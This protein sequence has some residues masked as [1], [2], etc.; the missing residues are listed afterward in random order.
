[1]GVTEVE[2]N[3]KLFLARRRAEQQLQN[4][5]LFLRDYALLDSY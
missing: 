4:D 1:M 2:F 3:R 5:P